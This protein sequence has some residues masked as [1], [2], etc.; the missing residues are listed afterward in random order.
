MTRCFLCRE[1]YPDEVMRRFG[2]G[3]HD[4]ICPRCGKK[5]T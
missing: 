2:A 1:R 3:K 4:L 5:L